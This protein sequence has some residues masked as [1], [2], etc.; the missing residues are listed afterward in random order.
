MS[1]PR[2]C[3]R[4]GSWLILTKDGHWLCQRPGCPLAWRSQ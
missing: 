1:G 3:K 2:R 4:C